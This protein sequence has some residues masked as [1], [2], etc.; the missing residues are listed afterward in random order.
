VN[1]DL[2]Y[3]CMLPVLRFFAQATHSWGWAIIGLTVLVRILVSPLV[4]SS[5]LQMRKMSQLQPLTKAIQDK[6]KEDP[7]QLQKKLMEF[8]A[9]NK[10][11][12]M[13]GCLPML[14]QL[15]ILFALYA[16]FS[17]P[18]FMEKAI[19][20]PVKVVT[21][22]QAGLMKRDEVSKNTCSYV[23]PQGDLSKIVVFP[24]EMT[25]PQGQVVDFHTR[26]AE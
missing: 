9:K 1:F 16:S 14:V 26:A 8:Y 21:P 13:G 18:P 4:T 25:I 12:P 7:E 19:D 6:Y 22:E 10:M 23:D 2:T 20:V 15:P 11:N 24:G 17:G 5:T 3:S